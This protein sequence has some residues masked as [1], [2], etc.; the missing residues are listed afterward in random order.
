[1]IRLSLTG[2]LD[3]LAS[4]ALLG[5]LDERRT[6]G[7]AVRLDLSRLEFI[8]SSGVRAILVSVREAA[9]AAWHIEVDPRV[10]RQV[11]RVF[12]LLGIGSA[13]W[14]EAEEAS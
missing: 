10:S 2:E 9:S 3:H 5:R 13:L 6:A 12:D 11:K 4:Q 7:E 14:P 8:D 1:M